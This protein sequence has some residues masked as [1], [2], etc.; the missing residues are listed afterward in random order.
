[1]T[2][3]QLWDALILLTCVLLLLL[4]LLQIYTDNVAANLEGNM[5]SGVTLLN[6]RIDTVKADLIGACKVSCGSSPAFVV[7]VCVCVCVC[8]TACARVCLLFWL[9][10]VP[11]LSCADALLAPLACRGAWAAGGCGVF[12]FVQC[13]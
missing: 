6:D 9:T 5:T 1:M 12:R 7:C 2:N 4:L 11:V 10:L 8:V 13:E 3:M